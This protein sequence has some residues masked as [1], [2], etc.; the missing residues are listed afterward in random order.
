MAMESNV[1]HVLAIVWLTLAV[2]MMALLLM[3]RMAGQR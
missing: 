1:H 2:M 3:K